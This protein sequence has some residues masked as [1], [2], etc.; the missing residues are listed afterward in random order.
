MIGSRPSRCAWATPTDWRAEWLKGSHTSKKVPLTASAS[1][2]GRTTLR[3]SRPSRTS[4]VALAVEQRRPHDEAIALH[5]LGRITD[6]EAT[7]I[8]ARDLAASLGMRPQVA[9][10]HSDLGILYGNAGRE[11]DARQHLLTAESMYR[12]LDTPIWLARMERLLGGLKQ[13]LYGLFLGFLTLGLQD[14]VL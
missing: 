13:R 10:C 6:D 3:G 14:L 1:S 9:H 8:M 11:D 4:T 12:E 7:L 5:I 2:S